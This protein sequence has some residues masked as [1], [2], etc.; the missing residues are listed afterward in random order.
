MLWRRGDDVL[1]VGQCWMDLL[2]SFSFLAFSSCSLRSCR[3]TL[4]SSSSSFSSRLR[5]S[6]FGDLGGL[7]DLG[8]SSLRRSR[9]RLSLPPLLRSPSR[10]SFRSR[11]L[12]LSRRSSSLSRS[13]SLSFFFFFSFLSWENS[14]YDQEHSDTLCLIFSPT[15]HLPYPYSCSCFGASPS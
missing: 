15:P 1:C 2:S 12:S 8:R 14:V 3:T 4:L 10:L 5:R 6:S 7:G 11:S 9:S 13:R